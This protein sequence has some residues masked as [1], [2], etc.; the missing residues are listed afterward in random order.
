MYKNKIILN[1]ILR[2]LNILLVNLK[3]YF[4]IFVNFI[5]LFICFIVTFLYT[6]YLFGPLTYV[7]V[8]IGL[9]FI[10]FLLKIH[11]FIRVILNPIISI[12]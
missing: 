12:F 2:F 5:I 11:L 3:L 4:S 10:K 6:M 8:P 9:Y 1:L 7:Q